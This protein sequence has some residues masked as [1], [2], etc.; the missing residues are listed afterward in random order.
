MTSRLCER[1][2]LTRTS[3]VIVAAIGLALI[4]ALL[5]STEADAMSKSQAERY[6]REF[7][8]KVCNGDRFCDGRAE[9]K[10]DMSGRERYFC[11]IALP[12]DNRALCLLN[13]R[14]DWGKIAYVQDSARC[15]EGRVRS[16]SPQKR[17]SKRPPKLSFT[18]AQQVTTRFAKRNLDR[19]DKIVQ[20]NCTRKSRRMFLCVFSME[21]ADG[22]VCSNSRMRV[23]ATSAK[24]VEY[25]YV[26]GSTRCREP[27][28][29]ARDR[30]RRQPTN[31]YNFSLYGNLMTVSGPGLTSV[32]AA[33][34]ASKKLAEN[35]NGVEPGEGEDDYELAADSCRNA[36]AVTIDCIMWRT[37]LVT[38]PSACKFTYHWRL[39]NHIWQLEI[40]D[41]LNCQ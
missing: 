30:P 32:N 2:A 27:R 39:E 18:K 9:A 14:I 1:V 7:G 28:R 35:I 25:D 21:L 15:Q 22:Q 24:R 16:G 17:K 29:P 37:R 23:K 11:E 6:A 33:F 31:S 41:P 26:A 10:C 19:G 38:P 12:S 13:V 40:P 4:L 5:I 8:E 20:M 36:G 34:A 3:S